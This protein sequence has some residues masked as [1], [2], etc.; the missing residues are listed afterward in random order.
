MECSK[1][2]GKESDRREGREGQI[3][4]NPGAV[5]RLEMMI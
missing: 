5:Q 3:R 1:G 2:L 4:E